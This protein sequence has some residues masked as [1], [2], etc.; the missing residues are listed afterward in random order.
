VLILNEDDPQGHF[1]P[2]WYDWVEPDAPPGPLLNAAACVMLLLLAG[3]TMAVR[4]YWFP[5]K[6]WCWASSRIERHLTAKD[7]RF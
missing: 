5:D 4:V 3:F 6:L 2:L 1:D 7:K